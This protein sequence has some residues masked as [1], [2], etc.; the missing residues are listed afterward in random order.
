MLLRFLSDSRLPTAIFIFLIAFVL[1]LPGFLSPETTAFY[2]PVKPM[3]LYELFAGMMMGNV[4]LSK[5]IAFIFILFQAFLVVRLNGKFILIQ[6]RTFLPAFF[7]I[8]LVSFYFPHLQFSRYLFGSLA[9]LIM[10]DVLLSSYKS[11][12]NSWRFFEAGLILG[13]ASLFYARM[14]YFFPFIWIS[15]LILRPFFWREWILPIVGVIVPA[16][17]VVAIR[18][19][20]G[21]DPWAI[22]DIFYDNLNNFYFSFRFILPYIIISSYIFLLV[23]IASGYMLRVYQFRKIYIRNYYLAFFWLFLLSSTL[24]T[25]LTRFDPGIVYASA[26]PV[27]F[28][29]SNYFINARKSRGNR[30]LFILLIL[31]FLGN[32][33]NHLFGWLNI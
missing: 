10:L 4:L 1:W 30:L 18:Y 5:I 33:L 8:L 17:I 2:Y 14:I 32:G 6:E 31:I 24:F 19:L 16:F 7:F 15:Q 20:T 3:P 12:P 25:F 26:I 23:I 27:S 9:V 22:W 21:A 28:L 11:D 29:L 13:V